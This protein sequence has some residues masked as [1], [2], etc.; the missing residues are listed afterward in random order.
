MLYTILQ[1]GSPTAFDD[2]GRSRVYDTLD[3]H[4]HKEME[5]ECINET[6]KAGFNK[7]IIFPAWLRHF[8]GRHFADYDRWSM[9]F[10]A[11]P[12]RKD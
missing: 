8:S 2:P 10:N 11:F 9:S 7:L 3:I 1:K 5:A 6:I 12:D 4:M